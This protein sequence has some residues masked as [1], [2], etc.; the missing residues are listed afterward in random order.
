MLGL[1]PIALTVATIAVLVTALGW[2]AALWPNPTWPSLRASVVTYPYLPVL[3]AF[4]AGYFLLWTVMINKRF[5]QQ[6]AYE[7]AEA[8]FRTL[9]TPTASGR[10]R[11]SNKRP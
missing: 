3:L 10:A 4:D 8:L 1:K 2:W 11:T 9:E 7:Y 6:A 5:V